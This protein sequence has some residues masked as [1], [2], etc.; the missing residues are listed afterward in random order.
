MAFTISS[1]EV[2]SFIIVEFTRP[3]DANK[4]IDEGLIWQGEVFQYERYDR[5]CRLKQ[6]YKCQRYFHIGTQCT[7]QTV[8]GY[9]AELYSSKDCHTKQTRSPLGSVLPAK[10]HTRPG[11]TTKCPIR[12]TELAK[13]KSA[14]D[15]RQP[16]HFVLMRRGTEH[17]SAPV[18]SGTSRE[19]PIAGIAPGYCRPRVNPTLS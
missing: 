15:S 12:K 19:G 8:C 4:I 5:Q 2:V 9:C 17:S 14:Y 13:V 10:D 1:N 3:E 16:C 11:T 6:C 18:P 7:A